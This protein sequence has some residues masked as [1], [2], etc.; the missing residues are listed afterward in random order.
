[1]VLRFISFQHWPEV[2]TKWR[3]IDLCLLLLRVDYNEEWFPINDPTW[4]DK[5]GQPYGKVPATLDWI[6]YDVRPPATFSLPL[7][8]N[9]LNALFSLT[10]RCTHDMCGQ[11][12]R[13]NNVSW[14]QPMCEYPQNLYSKMNDK[15]RAVLLPG[16]WGSTSGPRGGQSW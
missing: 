1:M 10:K 5:T 3:F 9:E 16:A 8:L 6:S 4:K 11:F 15:Q 14:L 13:L 7:A 12:Y 2:R